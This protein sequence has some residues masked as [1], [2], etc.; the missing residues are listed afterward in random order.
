MERERDLQLDIII[1]NETTKHRSKI[2]IERETDNKIE[3]K[4]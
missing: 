4:E 2:D 1:E 3:I